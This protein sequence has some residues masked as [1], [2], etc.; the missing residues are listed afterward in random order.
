[1]ELP[2]GKQALR[3][4]KLL[5]EGLERQLADARRRAKETIDSARA[6]ADEQVRLKEGELGQ[7]RCRLT[8]RTVRAAEDDAGALPPGFAP[9]PA[10]VDDLARELFNVITGR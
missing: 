3:E 7:L 2:E 4:I 6:A 1:M 5:E 9:D 8:A 10:V